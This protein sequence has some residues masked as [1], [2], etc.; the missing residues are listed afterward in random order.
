MTLSRVL[1][2]FRSNKLLMQ[3][4]GQRESKG[5][6]TPVGGKVEEVEKF[7]GRKSSNPKYPYPVT[8]Q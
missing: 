3:V 8:T 6:T 5:C 2:G 4:E 1:T 7:F